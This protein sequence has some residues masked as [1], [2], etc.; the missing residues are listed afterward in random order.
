MEYFHVILIPFTNQ[1]MKFYRN[2]LTIITFIFSYSYTT[3]FII[4]T[5]SIIRI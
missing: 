4:T 3:L 2:F 5:L 1:S